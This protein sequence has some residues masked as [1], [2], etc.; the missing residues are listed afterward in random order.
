LKKES[1]NTAGLNHTAPKIYR[2]NAENRPPAASAKRKCQP[3]LSPHAPNASGGAPEFR[4]FWF[5]ALVGTVAPTLLNLCRI[6]NGN[7][8]KPDEMP[9]VER[10]DA[11][12]PVYP[13]DSYEVCIVRL[14]SGNPQSVTIRCHLS[15]TSGV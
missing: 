5:T 1:R 6:E 8:R 3:V 15:G 9:P 4:R 10:E 12:H 13:H 7:T 2:S 14:L 11:R